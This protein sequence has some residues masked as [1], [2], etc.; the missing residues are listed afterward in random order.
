MNVNPTELNVRKTTM[1]FLVKNEDLCLG[2]SKK[3]SNATQWWFSNTEELP[4]TVYP[5]PLKGF[6]S[7]RVVYEVMMT[8]LTLKVTS[9]ISKE[10]GLSKSMQRTVQCD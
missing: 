8:E 6:Y 5:M 2:S 9:W 3:L 1:E 10:L 4:L 7:N